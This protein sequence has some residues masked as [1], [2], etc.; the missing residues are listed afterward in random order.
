MANLIVEI[1]SPAGLVFRGEAEGVKA[2]GVEGSF[3]V[4][5]NHA[6]MISAIEVGS[7]RV[8][9]PSGDHVMIAT[10]GGFLEVERARAA[11][12]RALE[13]LA[14][15]QDEEERKRMEA[16]LTRARN[17]ARLAMGNVGGS[18]KS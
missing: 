18:R 11:E 17:R 16:A 2:P 3:E 8:T 10:S 5:Y 6:P 9:L 1:V 12:K 15:A 14:E 13:R 4:L 7:I